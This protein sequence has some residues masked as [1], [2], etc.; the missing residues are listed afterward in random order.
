ER[1]RQVFG[2]E[3]RTAADVG[4]PRHDVGKRFALLGWLWPVS[5]A[6]VG[7]YFSHEGGRSA[8]VVWFLLLGSL[9]GA[10]AVAGVVWRWL[11]ARWED[12]RLALT[13]LLTAPLVA[14]EA[15]LAILL[16]I[17]GSNL[18]G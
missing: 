17:L 8:E 10:P 15:G 1:V 3:V 6:A 12:E 13:L 9:L 16:F 5:M 2:V 4:Y 7:V 18:T 11:P 14:V